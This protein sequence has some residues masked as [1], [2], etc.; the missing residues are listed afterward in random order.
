MRSPRRRRRWR[1]RRRARASTAMGRRCSPRDLLARGHQRGRVSAT[2]VARDLIVGKSAGGDRNR[3]HRPRIS[4]E[5][6][7]RVTAVVPF[8]YRRLPDR[9]TSRPEGERAMW[10]DFEQWP[11]H[12]RKRPRF[13]RAAVTLA[14]AATAT[15]VAPDSQSAD[16]SPTQCVRVSANV[17]RYCGPASARLSVFPDVLFRGGF[18]ARKVVGGIALLH[19]RIGAKALDGSRANDGL[20]YFSLGFADARAK[21]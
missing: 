14:I 19:V 15:L 13:A 9:A 2:A 5:P 8:V 18:C 3:R 11:S 6:Q 10:F 4:S 16:R 7:R 21:P 17:A 1:R 12:R 20:S